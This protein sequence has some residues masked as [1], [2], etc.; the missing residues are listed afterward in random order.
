MLPSSFALPPA[1]LE[2]ETTPFTSGGFGEVYGAT[3]GGSP[4]VV[5]TLKPGDQVDLKKL[6]RVTGLRFRGSD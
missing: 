6:Q 1:P 5:K 2:R 4:V 3:F